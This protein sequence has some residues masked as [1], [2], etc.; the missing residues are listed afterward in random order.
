[1]IHFHPRPARPG[2]AA[3]S[4]SVFI[5]MVAGTQAQAQTQAPPGVVVD[6]EWGAAWQER[7]VVQSPN[8]ASG[9]RFALD[10]LTGDGPVSAPRVQVALALAPRHELRLVA[11]PLR[12]SGSGSLPAPVLF[13]GSAF[14]AAPTSATY[15][16]DSYRA[17]WRYTVHSAGDTVVKAGVTG[18]IRDA[19]ITL[20]EGGITATRSNTGFVPLLHLHAERALG[21]R[22]RL[23]FEGDGL[24][25]GRGRAF[26]L[27]LRLVHDVRPGLA[28]FGGV[29]VLDGGADGSSVYNFARFQYLTGGLQW[30]R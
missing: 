4:V 11:A 10:R 13:E 1:M 27:A 6:V 29:R 23:V 17:T 26:D 14:G 5:A 18:K 16:F 21:D 22:T 7:N 15:R 19:E 28:V 24:A 12:L 3:L 20:R 30:R 2:R 25:G 8:D 9:T